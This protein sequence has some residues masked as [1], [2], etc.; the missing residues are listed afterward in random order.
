M[1]SLRSNNAFISKTYE[2]MLSVSTISSTE[3]SLMNTVAR[4]N[5]NS[6]SL[7]TRVNGCVRNPSSSF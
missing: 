7:F 5:I 6:N 3:H 4:F 2:H 1:D